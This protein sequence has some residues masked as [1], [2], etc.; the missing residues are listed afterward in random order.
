M[1]QSTDKAEEPSGEHNL[2]FTHGI[3][4]T[5]SGLLESS[6]IAFSHIARTIS[7]AQGHKGHLTRPTESRQ[8]CLSD[9]AHLF[10][11]QS[12]VSTLLKGDDL[13]VY[14][15]DIVDPNNST[16]NQLSFGT[17]V[18]HPGTVGGEYFFTKGHQHD[19]ATFPEIYLVCSGQG[20]LVLA[21]LR[22]ETIEATQVPLAPGTVLYVP[23]A[24]AHRAVNTGDENLVF[25]S[26][27]LT[28]TGHDYESTARRG[29]GMR[30]MVDGIAVDPGATFVSSQGG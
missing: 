24:Y 30:V 20:A 11:D 23:G 4:V 22:G 29:L 10:A 12:A 21:D 9:L 18:L 17:T 27:W 15:V 6:P 19:P 26:A 14:E 1:G 16:K 28:D 5:T 13:V 7:A 3:A 25:F 2:Q 8:V